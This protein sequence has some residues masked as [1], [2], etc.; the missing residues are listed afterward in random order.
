MT[1]F[2]AESCLRTCIFTYNKT[3]T[4]RIY[5]SVLAR[6]K[7]HLKIITKGQGSS[8]FV[9]TNTPFSQEKKILFGRPEAIYLRF[10]YSFESRF[11]APGYNGTL[12]FLVQK[13]STCLA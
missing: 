6:H 8:R 7:K 4:L 5:V 13:M 10:G 11:M 9:E 2:G 1:Y 12:R 3:S